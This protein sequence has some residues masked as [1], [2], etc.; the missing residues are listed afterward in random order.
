MVEK[1]FLTSTSPR[2]GLGN[3]KLCKTKPAPGFSQS[4]AAAVV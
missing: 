1:I 3:G 2:F 4:I